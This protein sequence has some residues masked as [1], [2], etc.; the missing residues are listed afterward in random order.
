MCFFRV[1]LEGVHFSSALRIG[2]TKKNC[3][4]AGTRLDLY[5]Y[6]ITASAYTFPPS[7][8][9]AVP[10]VAPNSL[11]E[12]CVC[13]LDWG[14]TVGE[15]SSSSLCPISPLLLHLTRTHPPHHSHHRTLENVCGT[16]LDHRGNGLHLP[17]GCV[18]SVIY[19]SARRR[20]CWIVMLD[21]PQY[22]T[23]TF[24]RIGAAS[25]PHCTAYC[26]PRGMKDV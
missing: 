24:W 20:S 22:L 6:S 4:R 16:P 21:G 8:S 1:G 13:H 15:G 23:V 11:Q 10:K 3:H 5:L 12:E 26:I 9:Q 19:L 2:P 17:S 25:D 14:Y 7:P 18:Y